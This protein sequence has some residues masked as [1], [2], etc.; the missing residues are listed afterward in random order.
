MD[1]NDQAPQWGPPDEPGQPDQQPD[2]PPDGSPP[3]WSSQPPEGAPLWS[4]PSPPPTAA[5]PDWAAAA[6]P[7]AGGQPAPA[8][9]APPPPPRRSR[10][11]RIIIGI[12]VV[13]VVLIGGLVAYAYINSPAGH[14]F[15]SKTAYDQSSNTCQFSSSITT[16]ATTDSVY[17]IAAFNDTLEVG[18]TYTLA[19]TRDGQTYGSQNATADTKFNC[20][21]EKGPLGPLPA[22]TYNFTFAHNGK[23]EAEGTITVK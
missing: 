10:L 15:F 11:P 12:V 9:G 6:P 1:Q 5:P 16:A 18:D 22:G 19:V 13:V 3:D 14:V 23:T 8:W 20:Y 7:L 4:A 17:M 21:I 2:T